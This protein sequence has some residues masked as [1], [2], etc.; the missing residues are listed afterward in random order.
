MKQLA[1]LVF[2]SIAVAAPARAQVKITPGPEQVSVE[3]DGKPFTV[4]YVGGKDFNR[5]Y[6]H[7]LRSASG[8]VVTRSFPAGQVP[9]ESV[10]H[11]HHAGVFYGH[12]DVN[13][14]NYWAIQNV[15]TPPGKGAN[16]MGRIVVKDVS[17][18]SG[19][20]SG[21]VDAVLT[22]LTPDGKPLMTETRKMTFHAHP[23]LRIVDFDFDFAAIDKVVFRDTKEGTFALRVAGAL[24]E[25]RS[26]DTRDPASRGTLTNAQGGVGEANVWGKRSAWV[27]YA[28][29]LDGEKVG[30]VM[31][32][33]PGN[34]RHPTYW[35][36]R[37][38]GLHSINP[39]GVRDF[40]ND[41]TQDGSLTLQPGEHVR[42]RYR[43]VV[44]PGVPAPRLAELYKQYS[45]T[46]KGSSSDSGRRE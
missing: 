46:A 19:K 7:P 18:K 8:K 40:L 34:P 29:Q 22:W 32:D 42:F 14:F 10:D 16:T 33:H 17:A 23:E 37:G 20:E 36:S 39:F 2:L 13:G 41:K 27:D 30:V 21:T 26:K 31:M 4:F 43:V 3:I 6:L 15:P 25:Q 38:Y 1:F 5:P 9:G 45:E 12:G 44:H 11:P 28:G 24:D 35:H